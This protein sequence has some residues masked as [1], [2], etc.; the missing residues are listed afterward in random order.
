MSFGQAIAKGDLAVKSSFFW[1]QVGSPHSWAVVVVVFGTL[2]GQAQSIH[3]PLTIQEALYPGSV[4][5]VTRTAEPVS[6]GIPL[7]DS[8]TGGATDVSQLG[9]SGS[10]IGQFRV[11]GRW[12]SGRIQWVLVD[13]Q[14]NLSAGRTNTSVAL[15]NGSGTFGGANLA[16]DQGGTITVSTGTATFTIRKARFNVLDQVI[17]GGK[18]LVSSGASPGLVVVGPPPGQT[19]CPPCTTIYSS[20]NDST[21]TAVI[22]E[23]GPAKAVIRATGRHV[24]GSGNAYM[25][26][27]VR[28][29]F[30]RGK[31]HVKVTSILRNADYGKSN[32]FA[33]A[34]KG[35]EGYE[36]RLNVNL[37]GTANYAVGTHAS[38]PATGS[39]SASDNLYLYQGESQLMRWQDWCGFGCISYTT[40]T[41]YQLVRNG[42][43]LMSGSATQYPQGWASVHDG[44][45]AG[46]GIG[47]YQLAAYWP[48]SLE[49]HSG[50]RDV[51]IGIWA[52]Q[53]S[54]PYYQAWPQWS[55]HDLYLNF[56]AT[57]PTSPGEDFLR[58]QH[59]LVGRAP[60][61][62]YNNSKVFPY[63]LVDPATEDEFYR[64]VAREAKPAIDVS[65]VCCI[66]DHGITNIN[67]PLSIYRFY[68]WRAGGGANQTEFRWSY[69]L[70]F[71][72]RGMTGRFLN[73][74]H[75]YRFQAE[76]F[77][78]HSD[79]FDWRNLPH[80]NQPNPELNGF[81]QPTA[82]SLNASQAHRPWRDQEHGHW[83]GMPDYYFMTGDET[84][85]EAM[86][87]QAS[88]WYLNPNTYQ[89]GAFG[90]LYN[91]RSIGI[92]LISAARFAKFL[93]A[94]GDPNAE[95]VLNQGV[96]VYLSQVKPELCVSGFPAGCNPGPVNGGP[97]NTQGVSR[98]RGVPWGSAGSSGTWCGVSRSYRLTS[99]FQAAILIQGL[100]ELREAKGPSWS[101]YMTALDLAHG[102]AQ[103]NLTEAYVD[104]GSGR[105]D[106]NGFRFA[107]V[108][109]VPNNCSAPGE[110][111][112]PNVNPVA[113]QTTTMTFWAMYL[114]EASTNWQTKFRINLQKLAAALG[115][116]TSDF[117][118]YQPAAI[119][120]VLTKPS[121][122]GSR[123][124]PIASV[125][126]NGGGS[127]TISWVAPAG[128]QRYRV[129]WG[130]K[131]IVDWIGFDPINN[132]FLGDP[133]QTMPWFAAMEASGAPAPASP[134]TLQTMTIHTGV[135]GLTAANFVVKA[136]GSMAS[137]SSPAVGGPAALTMVSGNGQSGPAGQPLASPFVVRV[138]D[139]TGA[140][141][142]GV[143][144]TFAVTSG[145]GTLTGVQPLT[146]SLGLAQATLV[147]GPNAG[148]NTVTVTAGSLAGS[149]VTFTATGT[150]A[151]APAGT[152]HI[153]WT[154]QT[155][156]AVWPGYNGFLTI[157]Y[158]PV[159][160]QTILYGIRKGSS[161]I[162]STDIF[163]YKASTNTWTHFGGTGTLTSTCASGS[164][165]QPSD[166]HP[167][168]QMSIDTKRN[169]LWLVGG[170]CRG[171]IQR[172]M[173]Y[174]RLNPNP[175]AN[176]WHRVP[177][178]TFPDANISSAMVYD[179]DDDVLF[180]FG[181]DTGSQTKTNWVYCPTSNTPTPGVLS[182]RQIAAGC[183]RPDDWALV[184]PVGG[185]QPPGV[186]YPGMV[187]DVVTKKV[188]QFGGMT[189]GL[190]PRNETWAYDVPTRT[191]TRKALST[192]SPPVYNGPGTA[193]PAMAYIPTTNKI[194]YHQTS[195]TGAPADWQYDPVADTWTKLSSEG[196]GATRDQVLAYDASV[197]RLI[198]FNQ[199]PS[200]GGAQVWQGILS[201]SAPAPRT[202]SC[203]LNGDGVINV[204]D[205]QL[206]VRQV[207]GLDGC[208]TADLNG[209]L[210]CN[211]ID[212]QRVVNAS[213]GGACITN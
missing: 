74:A 6:V 165:T 171:Q 152:P 168:W 42:S 105:W 88:D 142:S 52:Q 110:S 91:T 79:G 213:L 48:K 7:P 13:T 59:Y 186:N 103:W 107:L 43:V 63:P 155:P 46:I 57:A 108:L 72:T 135:T 201:T 44:S 127:Y 37:T 98:T 125:T 55:I 93:A 150:S 122:G 139:A 83:Y 138:T 66:Q 126:S 203:D 84:I 60:F 154:L 67:W 144:V 100:L 113:N 205:V 111:P 11:L 34:Y 28:M 109:D 47:V 206:S 70:N 141:V 134:G 173:Y 167:G 202:A 209:D 64:S 41:G 181:S 184:T 40:D 194:I 56:Y 177:T 133:A 189:G 145:G 21:S 39:L 81:G 198:G 22:E 176:T 51:R 182:S 172:D 199:D 18:T 166:R 128:A 161:S 160:Q 119:I 157:W 24:D 4:A 71:I 49:F 178:T 32:T 69:L 106:I 191:W 53:N 179:P 92:Q 210:A 16:T 61:T 148:T 90:G 29:Y 149:P 62:H 5:G 8:P 208:S 187:Y 14:V 1:N 20:A 169:V 158:D 38:S 3:V 89:N 96:N 153:R 19:T 123:N 85:R 164:D 25:A 132:T 54:K 159:S 146:N 116:L 12:P 95:A 80:A 10:S 30:Y 195:N 200:T 185:V 193:Q 99:P 31:S 76:M 87:D 120:D 130:P 183:T 36:L 97:W 118:S 129:K 163:F 196:G 121:P 58:F 23:N 117:G 156:T 65:K 131:R 162:Y 211:V 147:L 140:P 207:L 15:T 143:S 174:M 33:S 78:P 75:F 73:A 50:G 94:I 136:Y 170:V 115:M 17:V 124:V 175:L 82:V 101:E 68:A 114:A 27:T 35:H 77:L 26:F 137:G 45:G 86:I 102:I 151:S 2:A 112:E 190:S 104:D 9:L 204:Q 188:I 212:L 192:T 197:N 180:L